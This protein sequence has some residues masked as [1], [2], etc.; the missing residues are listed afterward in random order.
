[1]WQRRS[2]D[3]PCLA[4]LIDV[5]NESVLGSDRSEFVNLVQDANIVECQ[6]KMMI[7][8]SC[9]DCNCHEYLC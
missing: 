7:T 3:I 8:G 1:M 4:Q 5:V 2:V 6:T 9:C